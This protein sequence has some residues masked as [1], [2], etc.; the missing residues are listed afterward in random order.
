MTVPAVGA[1]TSSGIGSLPSISTP[2]TSAAANDGGSLFAKGLEQ[3]EGTVGNADSLAQQLASGQLT[4]L[5]QYTSAAAKA[6]LA[7]Q[8]TVALR[9]KAVEAYQS[10]MGM[11]V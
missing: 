1:L 3:A 10:I 6:S 11:Q 8:M 7:V 9:D 2:S 4:D 5:S